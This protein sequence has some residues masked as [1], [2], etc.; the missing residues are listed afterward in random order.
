MDSS[1]AMARWQTIIYRYTISWRQNEQLSGNHEKW[2]LLIIDRIM[3]QKPQWW[4]QWNFCNNEPRPAEQ[5]HPALSCPDG[6]TVVS[7]SMLLLTHWC[8]EILPSYHRC[9]ILCMIYDNTAVATAAR[10]TKVRTYSSFCMCA[11]ISSEADVS[12]ENR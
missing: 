3:R 12:R 2:N 1:N 4:T 8:T 6:G 10:N 5:T 7:S 9:T 11:D